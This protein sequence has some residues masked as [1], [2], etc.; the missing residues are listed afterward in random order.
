MSSSKNYFVLIFFLLLIPFFYLWD[1]GN[2]QA[3]RQG[4][5]GFYLEIA[6]EMFANKS[7]LTPLYHGEHHWSKPPLH[8]WIAYCLY[9]LAGHS[10]LWL[11]RLS[12][13]IVGLFGIWKISSL[14]EKRVMGFAT[15]A[16]YLATSLAFFKYSRIYMMEIMLSVFTALG[17]LYFFSYLERHKRIDLGLAA[18][19]LA[20]GTMIKGPVSLVMAAGGSAVYLV[21]IKLFFNDDL[22]RNIRSYIQWGVFSILLAAI[23]F[24]W[25]YVEYGS[26][27][28]DYFFLR[29]NLGK[30]ASKSYPPRVIVQGLFIYGLPWSLYFV[31][32]IYYWRE[33]ILNNRWL[34]FLLSNF[35]VF[36]I[37]WF[38]PSQRS[39]HYAIPS[40][41]FFLLFIYEFLV[42]QHQVWNLKLVRIADWLLVILAVLLGGITII[43]LNI[44]SFHYF[45]FVF[46]ALIVL[47]SLGFFI[48]VIVR[49]KELFYRAGSTLLFLGLFWLFFVP[50][51]YLPLVPNRVVQFLQNKPVAT[52]YRKPYFVE[53]AVKQKVDWLPYGKQKEYII[54]H[55]DRY[56][57]LREE[58]FQRQKLD[59]VAIVLRKW[60]NWRK[61]LSP[62][63][64]VAALLNG[65]LSSLQ[66][67]VLLIKAK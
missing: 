24:V 34:L 11:G 19:F 67:N 44:A 16:L 32:A 26:E 37:I 61:K 47:L 45:S 13:V 33:R 41:P 43:S 55:R 10:S 6:K 18:L 38:I 52:Y 22:K 15:L 27:F 25:S 64:V 59:S 62:K 40:I 46:T 39:H 2:V 49:K 8:F 7:F 3:L 35:L 14:R 48:W 63:Q 9:S 57:I 50:H 5:E 42:K 53:V 4:T 12:T 28:F 66:E 20:A 29:E 23:W 17:P 31:A 58:I 21:L 56:I 54:S 65:D 51:F 60:P 1:L 30:F 36:F